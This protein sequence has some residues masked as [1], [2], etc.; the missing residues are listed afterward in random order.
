MAYQSFLS[1]GTRLSNKSQVQLYWLIIYIWKSKSVLDQ[2]SLY[3]EKIKSGIY[4]KWMQPLYGAY[5]NKGKK[6]KNTTS[7]NTTTTTITTNT[8]TTNNKNNNTNNQLCKVLGGISYLNGLNLNN[9]F[10]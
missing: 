10:Q 6:H 4:R 7:G 3:R 5:L 2:V 9:Y 8:T 1:V